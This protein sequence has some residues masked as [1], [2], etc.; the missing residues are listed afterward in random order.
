MNN[1]WNSSWAAFFA[2][3]VKGLFNQHEQLHMPDEELAGLQAAYLEKAIPRYLGPLESEG[4]SI[5]PCLV[6]SDLWPGNIKPRSASG[7]LCIFDGCAYW[8]HNEC[9]YTMDLAISSR[10]LV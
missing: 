8:G 2:Q 6:H 5:K 7:E 3:Q 10:S 1:T 4:R 9:S